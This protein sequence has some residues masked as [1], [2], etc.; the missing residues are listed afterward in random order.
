L[1]NKVLISKDSS[2][3][4]NL[5]QFVTVCNAHVISLKI[6]QISSLISKTFQT[7]PLT[8]KTVI[9]SSLSLSQTSNPQD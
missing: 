4:L 5:P 7:L 3:L 2:E 1:Q 8:V 9:Q 6:L